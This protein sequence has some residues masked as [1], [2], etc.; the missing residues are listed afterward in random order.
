ML[1][2]WRL[3]RLRKKPAAL[4]HGETVKLLCERKEITL[5]PKVLS[6]Y[7]GGYRLDPGINM[8]ITLESDGLISKLGDQ[9]PVPILPESGTL[10]FVKVVDVQLEFPS[11][12]PRKKQ[13][14]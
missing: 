11:M 2:G 12:I 13:A 8:L 7:V 4:A 14:N 3:R 10:F 1:M 9:A 6:R 5:D